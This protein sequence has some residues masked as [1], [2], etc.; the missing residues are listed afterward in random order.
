MTTVVNNP[1]TGTTSEGAGSGV[2]VGV[3]I[4]LI[5]LALLLIFGLPL[6]RSNLQGSSG[7]DVNIPKD[8]NV[9]INRVPGN[10]NP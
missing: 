8:I 3:I 2:V 4:A 9:D 10:V 5:V 6:M 1:A 7:V